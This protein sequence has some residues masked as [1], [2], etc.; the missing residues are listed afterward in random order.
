MTHSEDKLD[1]ISIF[2]IIV[3]LI[4]KQIAKEKDNSAQIEVKN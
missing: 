1:R 4:A 3:N 2:K